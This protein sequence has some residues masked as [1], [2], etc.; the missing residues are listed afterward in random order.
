MTDAE[1]DPDTHCATPA[2]LLGPGGRCGEV[3]EGWRWFL[4]Q[5]GSRPG[6]LGPVDGR[7]RYRGQ[8]RDRTV[9]E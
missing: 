9:D 7:G 6:C 1:T 8:R 2:G 5:N 3:D 4:M